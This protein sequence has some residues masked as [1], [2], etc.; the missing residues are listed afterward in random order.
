M[1]GYREKQSESLLIFTTTFLWRVF[2]F[3]FSLFSGW[4]HLFYFRVWLEGRVPFP[5]CP[6]YFRLSFPGVLAMGLT[7]SGHDDVW[8]KTDFLISFFRRREEGTTSVLRS[9]PII[10]LPSSI[11]PR[12]ATRVRSQSTDSLTHIIYFLRQATRNWPILLSCLNGH[13][14]GW[15]ANSNTEE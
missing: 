7:P 8:S 14:F 3:F 13:S 4:R 12:Q 10:W 11:F 15:P 5:S 1:I 9:Q 6:R 2:F